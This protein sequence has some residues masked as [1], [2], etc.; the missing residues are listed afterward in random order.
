MSNKVYE[1]IL[2][3][4]RDGF[5]KVKGYKNEYG[6]YVDFDIIDYNKSL[7]DVLRKGTKK[8]SLEKDNIKNVITEM[9]NT[10]N[11]NIK[12]KDLLSTIET[13]GFKKVTF[14]QKSY[15]INLTVEGYSLEEYFIFICKLNFEQE[16]FRFSEQLDKATGIYFWIKDIK[17]NYITVNKKWLD[18]TG[19]QDK[20]SIE[21]L[22]SYDVWPKKQCD[23]FRANEK[24]VIR[25]NTIKIFEEKFPF[26]SGERSVDTTIWPL[27]DEDN[28]PIG[29]MGIAIEGKSR[30]KFYENLNKNE[31]TFKEI[32][33]YSD[34]VFFIRD[35]KKII[36]MSPAYETIFEESCDYYEDDVYRFNDFFKSEK[37]KQGILENYDFESL[38]EGRAKAKLKNGKEK[39]IQ[40]KFLPIHDESG[41]TIKRIGI[42]TDVTKDVNLE[43]E[44]EK[45]R[46]DFFANISHELRTPVNLILSSIQVLKLKL[47]NLNK[48]DYDYFSTYMNIMEHNTFRLVKLI[49]NLIDSTKIDS[50]SIQ[51]HPI[52]EDIINFIEEICSSVIH[53]IK[54]K[55]MNLVFDTDKE[56][57]IISFDPNFIERIMLN[58]LSNAVKFNKEKGTIFVNVSVKEKDVVV[59][60]KDEGPGIP[61]E[62]IPT[63][64]DRFE[65]VR[66]KMKSEQEGSGIGLYIVKSL[67]QIHGGTVKVESGDNK[68][69]SVI[70]TLP[71]KTL[72]NQENNSIRYKESKINMMEVEFSDIYV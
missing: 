51:I 61:K 15:G 11:E 57:E 17:G 3:S 53:F 47:D 6:E 41:K 44:K 72:K 64:F 4:S 37:Q 43:E 33:K 7:L 8:S 63:I 16:I 27:L 71:R 26:L 56:E 59:E 38:N 10:N 50:D 54:S 29:T 58:I 28:H 20:S 18:E 67:V 12:I 22:N 55:N 9:F 14:G 62:K 40:Y 31:K 35:D 23:K 36:Y 19:F 66:T 24:E 68:G 13:D 45:L 30:T 46:L 5:L 52:N 34:A 65:Q 21:G 60:V 39:W 42:L 48:E 32:T 69:C 2:K 70:F 49:N 1:K 25:D